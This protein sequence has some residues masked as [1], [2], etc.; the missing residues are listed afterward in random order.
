[1]IGTG[2]G[3]AQIKSEGMCS[4][5]GGSGVEWNPMT[6]DKAEYLKG[7]GFLYRSKAGKAWDAALK[8]NALK[9]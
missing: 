2:L 1:M 7:V 4:E 8:S 5:Y 9:G 6:D 3:L